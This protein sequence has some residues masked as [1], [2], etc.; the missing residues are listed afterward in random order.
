MN[1]VGKILTVLICVMSLVFM[2][3]AIMLYA[4]HTNW[5]DVVMNPKTGLKQEVATLIGEK[6]DLQDKFDK[7]KKA[8]DTELKTKQGQLTELE[9]TITTL[10]S[11]CANLEKQIQGLKT[12]E[13][14]AIATMNMTQE[15][16]RKLRDEVVTLRQETR[17]AQQERNDSFAESVRLADIVQQKEIEVKR[18]RGDNADLGI[19]V[20]RMRDLLR[21]YEVNPDEDP[22]GVLQRVGGQVLAVVGGGS[23]ELS[24]GA[25]DG[26]KKGHQLEVFRTGAG[27]NRYIGRIEV[28]ETAP[29]KAV[30]RVIPEYRKGAIHEGDKITS[31]FD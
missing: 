4:T 8:L 27:Q 28:M 5:S 6:E 25:D 19:D 7:A 13:G 31:K 2:T 18:L 3:M 10:R 14:E 17:Q 29:D 9:N 16:L 21:K 24:I 23:V 20:A 15:T 12:S 22:A 26:L 11:R 1:F 30:A